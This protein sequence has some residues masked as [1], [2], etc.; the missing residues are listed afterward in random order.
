MSFGFPHSGIYYY[1]DSMAVKPVHITIQLV[2][3]DEYGN[4]VT[5]NTN[6]VYIYN[7]DNNSTTN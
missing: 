3:K 7:S 1:Y 4:R 5:S 6:D 2:Y